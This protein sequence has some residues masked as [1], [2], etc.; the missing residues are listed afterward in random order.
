MYLVHIYFKEKSDGFFYYLY[1]RSQIKAAHVL[2]TLIAVT[3]NGLDASSPNTIKQIISWISSG[4]CLVLH[5][6]GIGLVCLTV[7][8]VFFKRGN[9]IRCRSSIIFFFLDEK[10]NLLKKRG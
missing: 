8:E 6:M 10:N 2:Q 5:F 7:W 3:T 4:N 1:M 9:F